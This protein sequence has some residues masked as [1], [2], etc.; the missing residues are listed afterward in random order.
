MFERPNHGITPS[1]DNA[2]VG[3]IA[4]LLAKFSDGVDQ[5]LPSV[6]GAL[7][8]DQALFQPADKPV[9]GAATIEAFYA[10]RLTDER[11]RT[12]HVWSNLIV[13]PLS[14]GR[15]RFEAVL[16]N[17][18]FEPAVSEDA[19]QVRVGNVH[20]V[21]QGQSPDG[22]VFEEHVYERIYAAAMPISAQPRPMTKD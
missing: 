1:V 18:A 7:F 6:I 5:R 13:Y 14:A 16:V 21:C 19:L 22:W 20:G 15:A 8:S 3:P 2:D 9:I 11:R 4:L 10:G 12:R 17:Y